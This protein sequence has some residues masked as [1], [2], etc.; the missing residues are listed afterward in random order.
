MQEVSH[1]SFGI[2]DTNEEDKLSS[3]IQ[4]LWPV[5]ARESERWGGITKSEGQAIEPSI[6]WRPFVPRRSRS[7]RIREFRH[8]LSRQ[9]TNNKQQTTTNFFPIRNSRLHYYLR[10]IRYDLLWI[11][12]RWETTQ[13]GDELAIFHGAFF[14]LHRAG[15]HT[16]GVNHERMAA[17][18]SRQIPTIYAGYVED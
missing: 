9:T 11:C 1:S 18:G 14:G 7:I 6:L 10:Q 2:G 4:H 15:M 16:Y 12:G 13:T 8:R 3:Y 17:T 5:Q